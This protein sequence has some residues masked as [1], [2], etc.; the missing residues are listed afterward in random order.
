MIILCV[1]GSKGMMVNTIALLTPILPLVA[2]PE[3]MFTFMGQWA[4]TACIN[5]TVTVILTMYIHAAF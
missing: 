1:S 5:A 4:Y 3:Y 2:I